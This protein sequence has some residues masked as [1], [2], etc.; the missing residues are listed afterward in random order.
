ML[1][2]L[3]GL[4]R[5][6][7]AVVIVVA[8]KVFRDTLPVTAHELLGATR[9][10]KNWRRNTERSLSRCHTNECLQSFLLKLA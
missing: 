8:H 2:A 6:V 7:A 4:V 9:V 3:D 5:A 1:T 10:V